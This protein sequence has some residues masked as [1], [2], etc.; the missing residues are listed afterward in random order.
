MTRCG[1]LLVVMLAAGA[2][3][4]AD[5]TPFDDREFKH[6]VS[7]YKENRLEEAEMLF[8][9]LAQRFPEN[10]VILNNLAVVA[11]RR[12]STV[13]A[14]ALLKRT[15]ATDAVL[16]TAYRNLSAVYAHLASVSYREALSLESMSPKPLQLEFIDDTAPDTPG[17]IADAA[18]SVLEA[19]EVDAPLVRD[20]ET[21]TGESVDQ[22][23][24][25]AVTRWAQAWSRQDLNAYFSSY[26]DGYAPPGNS[27]R[28]WKAQ[29]TE[30]ITNPRFIDVTVSG[31]RTDIGK[32]KQAQVT[33]RQRYRSNILS[34]SVTKQLSMRNVNNAWKITG[35]KIL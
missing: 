20:P 22:S 32:K 33:F 26:I 18:D 14:I 8:E 23:I 19:R 35:E 10:A 7:A 3:A 2:P 1:V 5:K 24:T 13:H 29:R 17:A 27:H 25:A 11:I 34:S 30:R 4:G 9:K 16:N 21:P 31:V 15:I 6:A 12:N 28:G